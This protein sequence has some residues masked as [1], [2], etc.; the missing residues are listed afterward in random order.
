M[1]RREG[2]MGMVKRR[3][4]IGEKVVIVITEIDAG[5]E[6]EIGEEVGVVTGETETDIEIEETGAEIETEKEETGTDEIGA[7]TERGEIETGDTEADLEIEDE[8]QNINWRQANYWI[9]GST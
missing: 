4:K 8:Q 1:K 2:R 7:E 6:A 9:I 5:A 3:K